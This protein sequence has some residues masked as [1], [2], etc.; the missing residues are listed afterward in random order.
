M[1][2]LFCGLLLA[3]LGMPTM[4]EEPPPEAVLVKGA[5]LSG[6]WKI[7]TPDGGRIAFGF[8]NKVQFGAMEAEFCRIAQRGSDLRVRCL[9]PHSYTQDGEGEIE[10][11]HLHIAW[12]SMMLRLVIDAPVHSAT[13]FTGRFSVKVIGDRHEAPSPASGTKLTLALDAPDPEGLGPL[14]LQAIG[15]WVEG[16]LRLPHDRAAIARNA[17]DWNRVSKRRVHDF[18]K[19][20]GAIYL[21]TVDFRKDGKRYPFYRVYDVEFE[22]GESLCGLHRRDDGVIDGFLC[23]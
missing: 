4:A 18:G 20:L 16:G 2:H 12:G 6:I 22:N 7:E 9:G 23:I 21:G 14:L 5:D 3:V 19:P 15:E 1:R 17:E 8:S 11:G 13:A 10:D